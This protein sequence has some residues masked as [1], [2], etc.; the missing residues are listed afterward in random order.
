LLKNYN[1][2]LHE[3]LWEKVFKSFHRD[4]SDFLVEIF[5]YV[6]LPPDAAM[7]G[8]GIAEGNVDYL[9]SQ[10]IGSVFIGS[11]IQ[12]KPN[13]PQTFTYVRADASCLPFEKESFDVISAFSLIEHVQIERRADFLSEVSRVLKKNGL[14]ILQLPNRY[15]PVEQ[16]SFL[17]LIGYLPSRFH[18]TFNNYYCQVPS[19]KGLKKDLQKQNYK[20]IDIT[21][22]RMPFSIFPPARILNFFG[23]FKTFP[24]GYLIITKK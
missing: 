12:A 15:F 24:F 21:A 17:P 23:F 2:G 11:D 1:T 6:K 3:L 14:L 19:L 4:R 5:P 9:V 10:K 18:T 22:Y 7:L 20:I 16:H 13:Y 8:L